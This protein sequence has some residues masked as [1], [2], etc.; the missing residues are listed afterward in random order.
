MPFKNLQFVPAVLVQPD[1]PNPQNI[2]PLQKFRDNFHDLLRQPNILSLL[3]IDAQ[4]GIMSQPEFRRPFRLMFRQ[5]PEVIIKPIHRTPVEPGPKRRFA[6]RLATRRR[7]RQIIIRRPADHM[8]MRLDIAH[9]GKF[10]SSPPRPPPPLSSSPR[11]T[12]PKS[13]HST[14]SKPLSRAPAPSFAI[15][16]PPVATP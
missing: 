15:P 7:H 3:R 8:R 4:P 9:R 11:P 10:I 5:L 1:F 6:H 12:A 16:P 2:R 14:Q 13:D